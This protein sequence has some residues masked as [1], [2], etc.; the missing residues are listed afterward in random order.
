MSF[1]LAR[2][3]Y[4]CTELLEESK[5]VSLGILIRV[6]WE[7]L[8][9]HSQEMEQDSWQALYPF[10]FS[11]RVT[12]PTPNITLFLKSSL[13]LFYKHGLFGG[14][15]LFCLTVRASRGQE[16]YFCLFQKCKRS[17]LCTH[18]AMDYFGNC[19]GLSL[20]S[21]CCSQTLFRSGAFKFSKKLHRELRK[22]KSE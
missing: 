4:R 1:L 2:S 9:S 11:C 5:T 22:D 12:C 13:I 19:D 14:T 18:I 21:I 8:E 16:H 20:G 7:Q 15:E 3:R 17:G 6:F 10:F